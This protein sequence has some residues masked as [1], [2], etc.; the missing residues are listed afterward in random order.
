MLLFNFR[1]LSLNSLTGPLPDFLVNLTSLELLNLT[2]NQLSGSVPPALLRR[3][4]DG[5]LRL[6]IEGNP[7]LCVNGGT[8]ENLCTDGS[9][10]GK[11]KTT[12]IIAVVAAVV[13]LLLLIIVA[14][15]IWR[16]KRSGLC[17]STCFGKSNDDDCNK[18]IDDQGNLVQIDLRRFTYMELEK[19]TNKF[20]SVIGKGGFGTV[21]HACL[22][23]A[24]Q[25]AVKVLSNTSQQGAKE[26]LAEVKNLSK[27]HHRNLLSLVGYCKDENHLALVYDYMSEGSLHD[28]LGGKPCS[29]RVLSWAERLQI[30]Y[31]AAQGL[32][33]LHRACEPPIIH[34]DVKTANI[35][36]NQKL[37]A[38]LADFGL[39]RNFQSDNCSHISTVIAGT[40]GY[41]DPECS[42][43]YQFHQK[44][45]VYSFGVVLLE[46]I[47]RQSPIILSPAAT[48]HL[49]DWVTQ[50]LA[51]G[52]IGDI[53]DRRLQ[54]QY[55]DNSV[56]K[57]VDLALA[58]TK[59]TSIQRPSMSDVVEQ[60]KE[61]LSLV[62]ACD[63]N[64]NSDM[65][66]ATLSQVSALGISHASNAA[67]FDFIGPTAR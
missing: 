41:L 7:K 64:S 2:G 10:C 34:R 20:E 8:C 40:P 23:N 61:S 30:V 26:F 33:Y 48:I 67:D 17:T 3:S 65:E 5:S 59:K 51:K 47:T 35:L 31:E 16:R 56:W 57:V 39:S 14:F 62:A 45:D 49:T 52:N 25:V 6:S 19:I 22:E 42:S 28:H 66:G 53:V 1:D 21:Y 29:V 46:V 50:R 58:C 9:T 11:K 32:E 13:V 12:L 15:I 4:Q 55:N 36:L 38:K 44:S 63:N 60:L 54:G 43:T 24:F 18:L 37:E 27:V